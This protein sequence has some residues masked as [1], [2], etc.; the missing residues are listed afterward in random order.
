MAVEATDTDDHNVQ[1]SF[2]QGEQR[3]N[4]GSLGTLPASPPIKGWMEEKEPEKKT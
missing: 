3:E 1:R 4:D 2:V